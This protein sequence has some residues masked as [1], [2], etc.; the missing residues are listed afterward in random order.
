MNKLL[1]IN[2]FKA[3]RSR[4]YRLYFSGQSFSLMG[5]WMQRTAVY[6]VIYIQ[7][8]SALILGLSVF[9]IQFPTFLFSLLGGTVADRY[10]R[11][12]VLLITQVASMIQAILLTI[13]IV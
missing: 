12:K 9:A 7:T 4:N 8:H 13:I 6:W 11:Y 10:S 2:T 5:T 1:S 3:F